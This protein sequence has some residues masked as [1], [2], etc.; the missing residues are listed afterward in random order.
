MLFVRGTVAHTP[1][2]GEL[3]VLEDRILVVDDAGVI[4]ASEPGAA[5]ARCLAQ[6]G[7]KPEDVL[8]L[9]VCRFSALPAA[10]MQ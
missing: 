6:H 9:K 1:I 7:G 5:E 10:G 2:R 8:R 3:E 4:A